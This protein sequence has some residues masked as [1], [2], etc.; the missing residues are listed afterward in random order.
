VYGHASGD[1]VLR[2]LGQMVTSALR[3]T[4]LAARYGGEELVI[5][6][7]GAGSEGAMIFTER[8]K[9]RLHDED[10]PDDAV[11]AS[12]GIATMEAGIQSG[13]RLIELAD[14]AMYEA[15]RAGKN[16][17][18]EYEAIARRLRE[19]AGRDESGRFERNGD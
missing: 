12:F 9:A 15:K 5:V 16:R 1:E 10:W 14:W 2:R 17:I 3:T 13:R 4:D 6:L 8:L 11:T 7:P 18:V 19:S